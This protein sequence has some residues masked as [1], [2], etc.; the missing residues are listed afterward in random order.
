MAITKEKPRPVTLKQVA[1][2]ADTSTCTASKVLNNVPGSIVSVAKRKAILHAAHD[3]GYRP[4]RSARAFST[5]RFDCIGLVIGSEMFVRWR[6]RATAS[7]TIETIQ[8]LT[9]RLAELNNTVRFLVLPDENQEDVLKKEFLAEQSVDGLI[10]FFDLSEDFISL[11]DNHH[12]AWACA[13]HSRPIRAGR[14]VGVDIYSAMDKCVQRLSALG[15]RRVGY[16]GYMED[17]S[18]LGA[19]ERQVL[20]FLLCKEHGIQVDPEF[21]VSLID[22]ADSFK[23]TSALAK[24]PNL[25]SC[26]FY[27]ADHYAIT[28]IR[29][30]I[31]AGKKVPEDISVIGYD[32]ARYSASSAVPLATINVPRKEIGRTVA[33]W[34]VELKT[35][36]G[37]H[38]TSITLQ[39]AFIE[40]KS[41]G[42]AAH[43]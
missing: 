30:L 28:G 6:T 12:I 39:A 23:M 41:L 29:A 27:S 34:V 37:S 5:G 31:E 40:R 36:P 25:P 4:N 35:D 15:H 43:D 17:V 33:E 8:G 1:K 24:K 26:M 14:C 19:G 9:E 11:L 42:K 7:L 13:T 16:L 20:F 38:P 10:T 32:D 3:L 22:E 2:M 18:H 21:T